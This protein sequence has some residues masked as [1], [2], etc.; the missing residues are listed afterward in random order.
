MSPAKTK[1]KKTQAGTKTGCHF[2]VRVSFKELTKRE[3]LIYNIPI[4]TDIQ[5]PSSSTLTQKSP[6][7]VITKAPAGDRIIRCGLSLHTYFDM[8]GNVVCFSHVS[9][10]P[11]NAI[12]TSISHHAHKSTSNDVHTVNSYDKYFLHTSSK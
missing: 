1:K 10:L 7:D 2:P 5:T 8:W 6:T 12:K 3:A 9:L 4:G 11:Y